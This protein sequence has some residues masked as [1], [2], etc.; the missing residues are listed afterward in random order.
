MRLDG[1]DFFVG[2]T[3]PVREEFCSLILGG[4]G[5]TVS[6]LSSFDYQD[7]ANNE[8]TYVVEYKKNHWYKI[9]M[10]V[11]GDSL[12]AFIDGEKIIET[13][14]NGRQ[15]HIRPEVEPSKP[16][17]ISSFDTQVAYKN[18]QILMFK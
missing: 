13:E 4:W 8:T 11:E 18:I 5:G 7:A 9:R 12:R 14:I 1:I 3:F 16:L 17:G 15:V 6:G 10:E 2:L